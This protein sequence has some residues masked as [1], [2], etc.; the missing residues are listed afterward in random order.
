MRVIYNGEVKGIDEVPA[1]SSGWLV[2][3]ESSKQLRALET[4]HS[5]YLGILLEHRTALLLLGLALQ[6]RKRFHKV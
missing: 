4:F 5:L 2:G 6:T 3:Q 1:S